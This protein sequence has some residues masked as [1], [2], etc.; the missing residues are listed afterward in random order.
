MTFTND[1]HPRSKQY[2]EAYSRTQVDTGASI[3]A[4]A[5]IL[6][7]LIIGANAMIGAGAVVTSNVPP[8]AIVVGNPA[9]IIG[10]VDTPA[11]APLTEGDE[12]G[13]TTSNVKGVS[14]HVL[15][16]VEDLRGDLCV[17]EWNSDIPF[18]P[19]RIFYVYGVP[20]TSVRGEHAHK[21]CHQFLVCVHG[22]VSVVVDDGKSR[23]EYVLDRPWLGLHLAPRIWGVQYKYSSDA[24]L[25]VL[26]SHTYDSN[27]YIRSYQ[28]FLNFVKA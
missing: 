10:Y 8:N 11:H 12:I 4:N 17:A 5:T 7:D 18:E 13:N 6:P 22:S 28:E 20:N 25:M 16:H 14:V 23:E 27:D 15:N 3:G 1:K 24:V 21:Q 9:R 19:Q 2:P 26:A